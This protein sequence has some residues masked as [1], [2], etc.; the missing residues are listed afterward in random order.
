MIWAAMNLCFF[1]F[2]RSGELCCPT[3]SSFDTTAHLA[4]G[5][6]SLDSLVHPSKLFV[7]IKASK[8][9]PILLGVTL[10]LGI[11]NMDLCPLMAILPYV[12]LCGPGAGPLF[13][14][15]SGLFLTGDR[16]VVDVRR[17]LQAAGRDP[18]QYS[19]HSFRIDAATTAAGVEGHTIQ[20]LGRWHSSAYLAY[21]WL[22]RESLAQIS[23]TLVAPASSQ[24]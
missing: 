15:E 2:L 22:S 4:P 17:L 21:I 20:T 8:T 23:T 7:T 3:S 24:A 14:L 9:D 6:L 19:G 13:H 1:G 10:V 11:T 16:F 5:D 12:A 18:T